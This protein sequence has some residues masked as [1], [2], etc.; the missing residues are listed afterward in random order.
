MKRMT[1]DQ[2]AKAIAA[3]EASTDPKS[4]TYQRRRTMSVNLRD[5][6]RPV[7]TRGDK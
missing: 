4:P 7:P 2:I 5:P 1:V 3:F 6:K